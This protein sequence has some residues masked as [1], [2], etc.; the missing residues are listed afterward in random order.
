MMPTASSSPKNIIL[1]V[2][3]EAAICSMLTLALRE[4][5]FTVLVAANGHEAIELYRQ[6]HH[7]IGVVLSDVVMPE[8]DGPEMFACLRRI[9]PEIRCCFM[10]G[11]LGRYTKA[12]LIEMGASQV[13]DKPLK[14]TEVLSFLRETTTR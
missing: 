6:Q 4:K 8:M 3:D 10:S 14:L 5:G 1:V 7:Q 9:N 2:D 12:G 11:S 13:F